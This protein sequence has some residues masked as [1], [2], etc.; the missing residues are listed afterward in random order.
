MT[1]G[2]KAMQNGPGAFNKAASESY[3]NLNEEMNARLQEASATYCS[4]T[5][6][7]TMSIAEVRR[8]GR[9]IF[10]KIQCLVYI[11]LLQLDLGYMSAVNVVD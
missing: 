9:K 11:D 5:A 4:S 1:A 2:K 8:E 3:K 7:E 10:S 6:G